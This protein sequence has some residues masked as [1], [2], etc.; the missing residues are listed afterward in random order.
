MLPYLDIFFII[1]K[2][3]IIEVWYG[4]KWLDLKLGLLCIP[5]I[6][7]FPIDNK[8]KIALKLKFLK[9]SVIAAML[10]IGI[11]A[12]AKTV[13]KPA[14]SIIAG[15]YPL[16][17]QFISDSNGYVNVFKKN[18]STFIKG[19]TVSK[20]SS[21]FLFLNGYLENITKDS[22]V[23]VGAIKMF[24]PGCCGLIKKP[25]KWTFRRSA[26]RKFFR[27][28]EREALCDPYTCY[29]YIDIHVN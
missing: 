7:I 20:D 9:Y 3:S 24:S 13:K 6:Q 11:F 22:F 8:M 12:F 29:Y 21:G 23:Y 5:L 27:L 4:I 19:Q 10:A 1:L 26:N 14:E 16:T 2:N 18:D 28:K 15:K 25:G 17:V